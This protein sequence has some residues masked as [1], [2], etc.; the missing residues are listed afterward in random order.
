MRINIG[1][2]LATAAPATR[3]SGKRALVPLAAALALGA[4][5]ACGGES[6]DPGANGIVAAPE[7]VPGTTWTVRDTTLPDLIE[8][9]GTALPL[10]QATLSTRLMATVTSVHVHEGDAVAAGQPLVR[11]DSRDLQAREAQVTAGISA[12]RA[13]YDEAFLQAT[14]IR[15]LYADSAATRAQLDAVESALARAESGLNAAR[16]AEGELTA[17]ASYAT[18]RAPF[19]G[20]V[21]RRFVDAGA[22]AAPGAP[23][24]SVQDASRLR[25]TVTAAPTAV[26]TVSRGQKIVARIEGRTVEATVEGV[27]PAEGGNV[28]R[29]NALVPNAATGGG[30]REFLAGSAATLELPMG[31]RN[32]LVVPAAAIRRQGDL[33]GVML[34]T[35]RGDELRWVRLGAE[36]DGL[37]EVT[38]GLRAGDEVVVPATDAAGLAAAATGEMV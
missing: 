29:V 37:V 15:A 1:S 6:S 28:Y 26:R 12:A 14:R 25:I 35:D 18:I 7:R 3:A 19:A 38:A 30:A 2:M 32:T 36:R 22:F 21:T 17:T 20:T 4:I 5:A 13:M 24:V 31:T 27:V 10:Q 33:T 34:R 23:I 16:A 11:L 9:F 8:A